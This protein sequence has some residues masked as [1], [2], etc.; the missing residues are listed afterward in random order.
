V[1]QTLEIPEELYRQLSQRALALKTTV[2]ALATPIL[3]K[4]AAESQIEAPPVASTDELPYTVWKERFDAHMAVV[5]TRADRYPP[6]HI[7]D[8]SREGMNEGCGE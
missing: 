1:H 6:D 5:A 7:T 3:A 4:L 8:V 2:E